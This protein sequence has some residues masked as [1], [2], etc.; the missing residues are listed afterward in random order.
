MI[1]NSFSPHDIALASFPKESSLENIPNTETMQRIIS[2]C[3]RLY[4]INESEAECLLY[5]L[6]DGG[7]I[8]YEKINNNYK[9]SVINKGISITLCGYLFPVKDFLNHQYGLLVN[10]ASIDNPDKPEIIGEGSFNKI[11]ICQ[12]YDIRNNKTLQVAFKIV[13][14]KRCFGKKYSDLIRRL[15]VLSHA[16]QGSGKVR[17]LGLPLG[18]MEYV[19]V[20]K[21]EKVRDKRIYIDQLYKG[22]VVTCNFND[23]IH[24]DINIGTRNLLQLSADSL[25]GLAALHDKGL[26]H[27]DI[28]GENILFLQ[29]GE[30]IR[31]VL[32]D[33]DFIQSTMVSTM[34][35]AAPEFIN[36]DLRK[37]GSQDREFVDD[38]LSNQPL[39]AKHQFS[40]LWCIGLVLLE[41]LDKSLFSGNGMIFHR[42]NLSVE[43]RVLFEYLSVYKHFS[44]SSNKKHINIIRD[45]NNILKSMGP[46]FTNLIDGPGMD[47]SQERASKCQ[48]MIKVLMQ[49]FTQKI[50]EIEDQK[51]KDAYLGLMKA[52]ETMLALDPEKRGRAKE[53][54]KVL[55]QL[56]SSLS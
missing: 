4:G 53:H 10:T 38:H 22:D 13:N 41:L 44:Y 29:E 30:N 55:D 5:S 52:V 33:F 49:N 21:D 50:D 39:I 36:V 15:D 56:L 37:F 1:N 32:A 2:Y 25:A 26:W 27:G 8:K 40:D 16:F 6:F 9:L 43:Y 7:K 35:Y 24:P 14:K 46:G 45:I 34:Y 19:K 12:A 31:A 18:Y 48:E 17:G 51:I 42:D 3:A 23:I 47:H 11:R 28:K 20:S 54:F